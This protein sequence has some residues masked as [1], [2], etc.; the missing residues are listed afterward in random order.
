M[1]VL[2][3]NLPPSDAYGDFQDILTLVRFLICRSDCEVHAT[4]QYKRR[5][6]IQSATIS[7]LHCLFARRHFGF[8]I[9]EP[10]KLLLNA[11]FDLEERDVNQ[12]TPLLCAVYYTPEPELVEVVETLLEA[13]ARTDIKNTWDESC[14]HLLL[15]RISACNNYTMDNLRAESLVT[16][17]VTLLRRDCDPTGLNCVG[18]TPIDAAMS[19][20]AWPLVCHALA[21]AGKDIRSLLT[22]LDEIRLPTPLSEAENSA[23]FADFVRAS[24]KRANSTMQELAADSPEPRETPCYLCGRHSNLIGARFPFDHF[25]SVVTDEI[26]FGIH[27]MLRIHEESEVC[28]EVH[29]EDSLHWLDFVPS[30]LTEAQRKRSSWKAHLAF[31]LWQKSI[32]KYPEDYLRFSRVDVSSILSP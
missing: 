8:R 14:L 1:A 4:Y 22:A 17:L 32:L 13:G 5:L 6:R 25:K 30:R 26:G 9:L 28:L 10:L 29:E 16:V 31:L 23:Q 12:N 21:R 7:G 24:W 2:L 3:N 18:F 11:G 15:R 27:L 20:T 19:P